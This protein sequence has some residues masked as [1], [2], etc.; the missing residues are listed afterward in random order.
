MATLGRLQSGA[1]PSGG[2][3]APANL[4]APALPSVGRLQ[5]G[6]TTP[7]ANVVPKTGFLSGLEN[8]QAA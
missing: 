2:T 6:K 8:A 5:S 4:P 1:T 3:A 7:D